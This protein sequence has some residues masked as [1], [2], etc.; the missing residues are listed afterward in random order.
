ME[1]SLAFTTVLFKR[2]HSRLGRKVTVP[3][4]FRVCV[5]VTDSTCLGPSC[6]LLW[7]SGLPPCCAAV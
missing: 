6:H 5:L 2:Y 3:R 7:A 4:V 1:I